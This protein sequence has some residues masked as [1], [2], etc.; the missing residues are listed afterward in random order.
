MAQWFNYLKSGL[1]RR[2]LPDQLTGQDEVASIKDVWRTLLPYIKMNWRSGL[3][4]T[5]LI[6]IST[7][8]LFPGP[9]INRFLI[10]DVILAHRFDLLPLA[11]F[12]FIGLKMLTS[13][14][15][16]IKKLSSGELSRVC[17]VGY[18]EITA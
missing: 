14:T 1:S 10:D 5:G 3:L 7:L 4:S 11:I 15:N 12:F 6:I 13:G 16:M 8:L 9:L 17:D 18:S 2:V